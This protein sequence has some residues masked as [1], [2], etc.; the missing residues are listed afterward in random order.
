MSLEE[1]IKELAQS[2]RDLTVALNKP[3]AGTLTLTNSDTPPIPGNLTVVGSSATVLP[4][5]PADAAETLKAIEP[6]TKPKKAKAPKAEEPAPA[7]E[8][9]KAEEPA[10]EAAKPTL[11]DLRDAAQKALD[12]GKLSDVVALN[13][14]LGVKRISEAPEDRWVEVIAKLKGLANG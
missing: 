13:K 14:E 10:P 8:A 2:I 4:Y 7:P 12:A 1:S 9:P 3:C 5:N 6:V 11:Q